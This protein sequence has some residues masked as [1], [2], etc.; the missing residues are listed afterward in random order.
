[1]V[2]RVRLVVVMTSV[3]GA[4]NLP[5][6][7]DRPYHLLAVIESFCQDALRARSVPP[8]GLRVGKVEAGTSFL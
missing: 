7:A 1:M 2:D 8:V 4:V 3:H 5:V 6:A